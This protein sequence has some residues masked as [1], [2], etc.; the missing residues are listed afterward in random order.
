MQGHVEADVYED[1]DVAEEDLREL[2]DEIDVAN[3]RATLQGH[4]D[5]IPLAPGRDS[6][7]C[8]S[9]ISHV[10]SAVRIFAEEWI[11][12]NVFVKSFNILSKSRNSKTY[13]FRD[14]QDKDLQEH[15]EWQIAHE[16]TL[17][18]WNT[19][20]IVLCKIDKGW[21]DTRRVRI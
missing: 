2:L 15:D 16:R 14:N 11:L 4:A 9:R 20:V 13:L 5:L 17:D 3:D 8:R 12:D 18:C 6:S 21:S 19:P 10:L 7:R 1:E